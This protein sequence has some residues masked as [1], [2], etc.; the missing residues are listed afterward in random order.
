MRR[1]GILRTQAAEQKRPRA[2]TYLRKVGALCAQVAD[3][4]NDADV[5]ALLLT[6]QR[7]MPRLLQRQGLSPRRGPE[8]EMTPWR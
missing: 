1:Y 3:S 5:R 8:R 6:L 2:R 7:D 4:G